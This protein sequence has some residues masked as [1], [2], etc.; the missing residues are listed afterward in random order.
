MET[1][2]SENQGFIKSARLWI[3]WVLLVL[4]FGLTVSGFIL[5]ARYSNKSFSGDP[6]TLNNPDPKPGNKVKAPSR[7]K[8]PVPEKG[9][10]I[11][12]GTVISESGYGLAVI[13][14]RAV[15]SGSIIDGV[16][17]LEITENRVLIESGGKTVRL[18]PGESFVP[19]KH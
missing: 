6:N 18:A 12:H 1:S 14:G 2:S 13:N 17:I 11:C 10:I 3:K 16:K 5:G 4:F 7:E 9:V 8:A 15:P 19:K